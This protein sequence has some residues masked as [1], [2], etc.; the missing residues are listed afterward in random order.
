MSCAGTAPPPPLTQPQQL[1][2]IQATDKPAQSQPSRPKR[3]VRFASPYTY[4]WFVRAELLRAAGRLPDAIEAYRA[5]AAG[6]DEDPHLL[7]RLGSALASAGELAQAEHVLDEAL[8]LDAD[9]EAVWLA[10]AE[11]CERRG[12][13]DAQLLALERAEHA[14]PQSARGPLALATV[15]HAQGR[16]ERARAVLERYRQRSLPGSADAHQVEL[17]HATAGGDPTAVFE[18]SL[19][20]RLGS[21]VAEPARLARAARL[22]LEHDQPALAFRVLELVPEAERDSTLALRVL[23]ETGSLASLE[24]WLVQHGPGTED[25]RLYVARASLLLGKLDDAA[26]LLEAE[27]L[28]RPDSPAVQLL[29]AELELARR[30][31]ALA[32]ELFAQVPPRSSAGPAAQRGLSRA[33]TALGLPALGAEVQRAERIEQAQ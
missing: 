10:R 23:I 28:T 15:L 14:A 11:L 21:P 13:L 9:S 16:P 3:M 33:L 18:A 8:A 4:E 31:Y 6:A 22:L 27:R 5:A 2:A 30:N 24:S 17:E 25:E 26:T 1:A 12:D 20:Y 29:A 32:A 19:P 7:A